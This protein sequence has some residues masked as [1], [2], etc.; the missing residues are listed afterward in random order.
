MI[1]ENASENTKKLVG[2]LSENLEREIADKMPNLGVLTY[3]NAQNNIIV[4]IGYLS[5]ENDALL[6]MDD[7]FIDACA[8]A[9][10]IKLNGGTKNGRF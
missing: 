1:A 9:I 8:N 10:M 7:N 4:N 5:N 3:E 6:L 2:E